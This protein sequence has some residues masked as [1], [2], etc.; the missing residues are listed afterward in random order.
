MTHIFNKM[1]SGVWAFEDTQEIELPPPGYYE[2]RFS[3][4]GR[5]LLTKN[6]TDERV[7]D[8]DALTGQVLSGLR[9]FW[10]S[11]Q[12]YKRYQ[13][14][15]KRGYLLYG[16]PGT[17]KSVLL[18]QIARQ[19]ITEGGY[20]IDAEDMMPS[21]W[22]AT[23]Q[24]LRERISA[25]LLFLCE[26]LDRFDD[27]EADMTHFLDGNVQVDGLAFVATTNHIED[28]SERMLRP[29]R[30]DELVHVGYPSGEARLAYLKNVRLGDES[31]EGWVEATEGMTYAQI[32]ELFLSVHV[33]GVEFDSAMERLRGGGEGPKQRRPKL[34]DLTTAEC[35][36]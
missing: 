12:A 32:K 13:V 29:S 4:R 10:S 1:E 33:L 5:F 17:G 36:A 27:E 15:H 16:P 26:D 34:A 35:E 28:L 19:V 2:V 11:S 6:M 31:I 30:L 8:T 3:M 24:L 25:P 21:R 7:V 23:Y 9:T 20:V 18:R 22:G 14:P